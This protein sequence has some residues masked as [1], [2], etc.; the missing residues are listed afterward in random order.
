V[1][2]GGAPALTNSGGVP[3]TAAYIDSIGDPTCDLRSNIAA[4][5]RAKIVYE[6]LINCTDDP[7]VKEAL[8]FLMTR[9][10]AHQQQ[11]EKALYSIEPNF[12][13][14]KL[15]GSPEFTNVYFNMSSGDGDMRGPWNSE[16]TFEFREAQVAVDGG[17][18][19]PEVKLTSDER[20]VLEQAALRLHSDP[21]ADPMTGAMLGMTGANGNGHTADMSDPQAAKKN[22]Q[23]KGTSA[24]AT[25]RS[26]ASRS[27]K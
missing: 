25:K 14:G 4:E 16:P 17:S 10:I 2:Y 1:L 7:G 22:A 3:W 26:T 21:T 23:R 19:L 15:P 6:R 13:P 27:T 9:E 18:G 24:G 8:G 11:F 20:Q 12:P 5:A